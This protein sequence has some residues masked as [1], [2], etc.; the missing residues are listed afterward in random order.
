MKRFLYLLLLTTLLGCGSS[1]DDFV[2]TPSAPDPGLAPALT[3][4]AYTTVGNATVNFQAAAGVLNNDAPNGGTITAFQSTSAQNGVVAVNADGSFSYTPAFG[5]TGQDSFTYTV[6][7]G[8]GTSTAT[9]TLQVPEAAYF[10]KND[11]ANGNGSLASPFNN[12]A[13]AVA[14][15]NQNDVIFLFRGDGSTN[16]LD[17]AIT[18]QSGQRLVGEAVGLSADG[19]V[20]PA[21]GRPNTALAITLADNNVITGLVLSLSNA[22]SITGNQ[23]SGLTLVDNIFNNNGG[24]AL[25]VQDV[26]GN[27][28]ISNNRFRALSGAADGII[29]SQT[30]ANSPTANVTIESNR[31][32]LDT[33]AVNGLFNPGTRG[34]L[35]VD[36]LLNGGN[37]TASLSQ[38]V[39]ESLA[40]G[41]E[42]RGFL[43]VRADGG[44]GT[45]TVANNTLASLDQNG[46]DAGGSA[47]GNLSLTV[48]SNSGTTID[49]HLVTTNFGDNSQ[50]KMIV[51]G[52]TA[53]TAGRGLDCRVNGN[54]TASVRVQQN[55]LTS[56][57]GFSL[58]MES[59]GNATLCLDAESNTLPQ[60]INLTQDNVSVFQVEQL[61]T[62]S[63]LNNSAALTTAG[64]LSDVP[65][66]TCQF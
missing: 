4:D 54:S 52:N 11:G 66:G 22:P 7:N 12:I 51:T 58:D 45:V 36:L 27:A 57:G 20:V 18:L 37:T 33:Q 64:T 30:A 46:V 9:V 44:Q 10:V 6:E 50:L 62:L 34:D 26:S 17:G 60:G 43:S 13:S 5:F 15:A 35:A 29:L 61:A 8:V 23:I 59:E 21:G 25:Q 16:G 41:S 19:V 63:N 32:Q 42:W 56:T 39:T 14:A 2:F 65:D 1:N 49:G 47:S 48:S 31:F 40:G 3:N 38:N 28:N 53:T 24:S 55:S